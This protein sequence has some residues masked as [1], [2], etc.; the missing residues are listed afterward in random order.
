[1]ISCKVSTATLQEWFLTKEILLFSDFFLF[2]QPVITKYV[3]YL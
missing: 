2:F 3:I 1:M